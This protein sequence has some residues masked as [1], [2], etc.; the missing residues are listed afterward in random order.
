MLVGTFGALLDLGRGTR[1]FWRPDRIFLTSLSVM[2]AVL[3]GHAVEAGVGAETS[4]TLMVV[5][6]LPGEA[7]LR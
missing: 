5:A 7:R 1:R 4:L 2:C 6:S 3:A